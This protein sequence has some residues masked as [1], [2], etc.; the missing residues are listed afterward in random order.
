[1]A[2]LFTEAYL[3]QIPMHGFGLWSFSRGIA[4][5]NADY[6]AALTWADAPRRNDSEGM[7][8]CAAAP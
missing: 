6:K 2:R 1:V 7:R 8:S 5:R 3:H 4:R